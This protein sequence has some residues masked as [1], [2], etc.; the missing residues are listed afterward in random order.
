MKRKF[1]LEQL[2]LKMGALDNLLLAM[3]TAIYSNQYDISNFRVGFAHLT[4][5]A[6]E[7]SRTLNEIVKGEFED[8]KQISED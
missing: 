8:A 4:D 7:I 5:M 6:R 2:S 1:E 3:E